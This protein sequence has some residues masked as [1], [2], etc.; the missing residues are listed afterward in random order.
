MIIIKT[1]EEIKKMKEGGKILA[2]ILKQVSNSVKVGITTKEL[3]S[4]AYE[5]IIK[6]NCKPAFL[7]YKPNSA[8][9]PYPATLITSINSEVVHGIPKDKILK[10]GD[11]ISL[12]LGLNYQG[13]F[14]DHAITIGVGDINK[15]DKELI[16][17]TQNA[18]NEAIQCIKP[19]S[20]VGD[21]GYAI[22]SYIKPY[23]FGIVRV[24]S[25]HGVGREIHEDPYIPNYG[26]KGKGAKLVPGMAIAI[27]PMITLGSEDVVLMQDGYTLKTID[28]SKSAHFEHTVLIT[29]N[30][31]EILTI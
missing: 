1:P 31:A 5:M 30:G 18:L 4:I 16:Y 20:T 13:V 22:E 24:L 8:D 17:V 9:T 28:N 6:A 14:L 27:E 26:K 25:G 21:I 29:E 23:K 7:G 3:D 12:D 15:K 19:G 2:S 11:I 10:N